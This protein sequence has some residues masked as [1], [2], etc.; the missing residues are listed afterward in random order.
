[1]GRREVVKHLMKRRGR[2]RV[3]EARPCAGGIA[4]MWVLEDG[5]RRV[6]GIDILGLVHGQILRMDLYSN[7]VPRL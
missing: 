6:D 2:V 3:A 1:M 4:V 7:V 5:A